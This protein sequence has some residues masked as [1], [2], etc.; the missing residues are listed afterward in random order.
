MPFYTCNLL[1][2]KYREKSIKH[3][4]DRDGSEDESTNTIGVFTT[5]GA[6]KDQISVVGTNL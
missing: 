4:N 5:E 1:L 6:K 3:V 2:I